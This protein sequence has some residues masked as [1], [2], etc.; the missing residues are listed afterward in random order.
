MQ[1]VLEQGTDRIAE[2]IFFFVS[3]VIILQPSLKETERQIT[4]A[5]QDDNFD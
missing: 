5:G 1:K 4:E 2:N 3:F